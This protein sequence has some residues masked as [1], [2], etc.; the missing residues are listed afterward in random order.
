M[1]KP[2]KFILTAFLVA[3][4]PSIFCEDVT[5]ARAINAKHTVSNAY[6]N[7]IY[8][9]N[10]TNLKLTD[11]QATNTLLVA[12]SQ[13][14]YHEGNS[15]SELNGYN[16]SGSKNYVEYTRIT[17]PL[18]GY[19]NDGYAY[20]WCASFVSWSLTHANV[21]KSAYGNNAP[22]CHTLIEN[23]KGVGA[24]VNK[25]LNYSPK[26]GDLIF[27]KNSTETNAYSHVGL[28]LYAD[29]D[30][31]YTVEGNASQTGYN[32]AGGVVKKSY[33]LKY[34]RISAY[35]TPKYNKGENY[36]DFS[37]KQ[38]GR[39]FVT[40]SALNVR[41]A[42]NGEI[43]AKAFKGDYAV[44]SSWSNGFAKATVNGKI[45]YLSGEYLT[46]LH[47]NSA[48]NTLPEVKPPIIDT[49]PPSIEVLPPQ[50][51]VL[52]PQVE[53]TP[54]IMDDFDDT[55]N[56]ETLPKTNLSLILTVS[57]LALITLSFIYLKS[58]KYK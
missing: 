37:N 56:I 47:D 44:V 22:G 20:A 6:K 40:A 24:K 28:V 46:Y 21:P 29:D 27:F 54:P 42:P 50:V 36:I 45:G 23:L 11:D 25:P 35:A 18:S 57:V 39:Y 49:L 31:V 34:S 48:T 30:K 53:E 17:G 55:V 14:G 1:K 52:P 13:V 43:I 4:F 19:Q 16:E 41:S 51:E 32:G 10:L 12:L 58:K 7:S 9:Q 8:Y 15:T 38:V 26:T 2:I 33:S 5:K 3:V